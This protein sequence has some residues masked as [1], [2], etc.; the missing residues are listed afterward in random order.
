MPAIFS[1]I[2]SETRLKLR[3]IISFSGEFN[4]LKLME[5]QYDWKMERSDL[6]HAEALCVKLD[7]PSWSTGVSRNFTKRRKTRNIRDAERNARFVVAVTFTPTISSSYSSQL[8]IHPPW[9]RRD[10]SY[11]EYR[12]RSRVRYSPPPVKK[13]IIEPTSIIRNDF[14]QIP[15]VGK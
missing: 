9:I 3:G 7:D 2:L 5:K 1:K 4:L 11:R 8:H 6:L 13:S 10:V 14:C 12:K 15:E